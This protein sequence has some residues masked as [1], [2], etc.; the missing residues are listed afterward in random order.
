MTN[1]RLSPLGNVGC[2]F[3]TIRLYAFTSRTASCSVQPCASNKHVTCT[4]R[5][6]LHC[7]TRGSGKVITHSECQCILN[8]HHCLDLLSLE[9]REAIATVKPGKEFRSTRDR[10]T[11]SLGSELAR[12]FTSETYGRLYCFCFYL[13]TNASTWENEDFFSPIK[14]K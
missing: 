14:Y 2:E 7:R 1:W 13:N 11:W 5:C 3:T 8:F 6:I 9:N 10:S 4:R 12:I